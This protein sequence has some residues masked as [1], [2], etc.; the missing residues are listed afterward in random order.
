MGILLTLAVVNLTSSQVNAR[1]T[2]RQGDAE[3]IV[4]NMESYYNNAA[5]D[6]QGN[7]YA[8]GGT[9]PGTSALA[10]SSFSQSLPDIDPKSVHA[11]G[12]DLKSAMSLV[13]ATNNVQT[14]AGVTPAPSKSNDVYVYQPIAADGSL[15]S[16]PALNAECR[17]FNI[18]YYQEKSNSVQQ[19][20][21]KNQ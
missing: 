3:A 17:K 18:Y 15:C 13:P 19:M 16:L 9:Y 8:I 20:T 6:S 4:K 21:S 1:D 10:P 12:V 2:E 11:P 7:T 14:T 5:Q